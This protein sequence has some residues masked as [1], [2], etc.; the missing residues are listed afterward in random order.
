MTQTPISDT[1]ISIH[2]S[3]MTRVRNYFLTGI[4]VS[5]PIVITFYVTLL[6]LDFVDQQ[7]K[8]LIPG[9]LPAT[10]V[11]GLGLV[12]ALTFFVVLGWFAT[13]FLGRLTIRLSEAVVARMPV[14]R[15]IYNGIKQVFEMVMGQQ[16]QAFREAVLIEFPLSG[17][18]ALG[19][20]TGTTQGEVQSRTN[21]T[22]I[23]VFVPTT[24]NPTS[25]FLLFV[26]SDRVIRLKMPVDDALK[27]VVSGGIL[28]PP[29]R[30]MMTGN[31]IPDQPE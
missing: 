15:T 7:V 16:A 30:T 28:T 25:G 6:F 20:V 19:F 26:P 3:V 12:I 18:W 1:P 31:M 23:N 27:M 29:D 22:V 5:A 21:A 9:V 13:N 4:L 17:T 24:P 2:Q 11:P 10:K 14:I 8:D